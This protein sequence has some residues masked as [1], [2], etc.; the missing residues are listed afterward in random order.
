MLQ[1]LQLMPQEHSVLQPRR[2]EA[3]LLLGEVQ[4]L[5]DRALLDR[6]QRCGLLLPLQRGSV[7]VPVRAIGYRGTFREV[8]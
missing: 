5:L 4:L 1:A 2:H 8:R 3:V 6:V 7:N